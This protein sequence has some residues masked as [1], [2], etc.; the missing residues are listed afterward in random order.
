MNVCAFHRLC[1]H[2]EDVMSALVGT[3]PPG[4]VYKGGGAHSLSNL[5]PA[6]QHQISNGDCLLEHPTCTP[7]EN[8]LLASKQCRIGDGEPRL[9]QSIDYHTGSAKKHFVHK[10]QRS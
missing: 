9:P 2:T 10:Q 4:V 1:G 7:K 5:L 6:L 8:S 3:N